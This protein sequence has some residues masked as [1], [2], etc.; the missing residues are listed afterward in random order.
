MHNSPVCQPKRHPCRT[1]TPPSAPAEKLETTS[2]KPV[3]ASSINSLQAILSRALYLLQD[4]SRN[5][6]PAPLFYEKC[7]LPP[8]GNFGC[9][10]ANKCS[11]ECRKTGKIL[12]SFVDPRQSFGPDKIIPP[13]ILANAKVCD[14]HPGGEADLSTPLYPSKNI[15]AFGSQTSLLTIKICTGPRNP[16][17]L[18]SRIP[19][20]CALRLRCCCCASCGRILVRTDGHR[21]GGRRIWRTDRLRAYRFRVHP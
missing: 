16:H 14:S 15:P 13:Q 4:A 1:A 12:A 3:L 7:V 2:Q 5:Q 6:Q 19:R 18:Q 10:V 9:N 8:P 21:H 11:G 17:C 20:Y